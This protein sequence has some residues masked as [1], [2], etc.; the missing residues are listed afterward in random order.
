MEYKLGNIHFVK[1]IILHTYVWLH[2]KICDAALMQFP[3]CGTV[4]SAYR[5]GFLNLS[6]LGNAIFQI[7]TDLQY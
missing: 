5:A 2:I 7:C 4:V 1:K 6:S 3:K